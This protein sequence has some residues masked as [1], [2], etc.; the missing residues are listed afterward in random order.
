M[1]AAARRPT[2]TAN[3][4]D[5]PPPSPGAMSQTPLDPAT[6]AFLD[7]LASGR[8]PPTWQ[9]PVAEAREGFARLQRRAGQPGPATVTAADLTVAGAAGPLAARLYTPPAEQAVA[10]RPLLLWL[11]G[12][13]WVMGGLDTH[14]GPCR[15]IAHGYGGPVLAVD[16]R[17]APEAP[18]PAALD[19]AEAAL[20]WA[21]ERFGPVALG[22]D[23]AGGNLAAALCL[24][25]AG[26]RAPQPV[27]QVLVYPCLD[28]TLAGA[29]HAEHGQGRFLEEADVL[30]FLDHYATGHG[31]SVLDPELSPLLAESLRGLPP[32]TVVIAGHD[33]LADDGRRWV[34]RLRAEGIGARLIEHGGLIHGFL[35][36]TAL[37]PA[38]EAA[39]QA[40]GAEIAADMAV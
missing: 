14:D 5:T 24:R 7:R 37:I 3:R 36:M 16:Y 11:H 34:A 23:S 29:S 27:H 26:R 21:M 19:D 13:G 15:T 32:A 25:L 35:H 28:A 17:L 40:L 30:W 8:R 4:P 1:T 2:L 22:G 18:F 12:G 39:L 31:V 9:L 6:R 38:A 33:P 20:A 10:A